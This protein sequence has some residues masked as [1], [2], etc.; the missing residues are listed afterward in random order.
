MRQHA[1]RDVAQRRV[2][3]RAF[4]H[5]AVVRFVVL[6][7]KVR[8]V[9]AQRQQKVIVRVVGR[10]KQRDGFSDNALQCR[11]QFRTDFQIRRVVGS[12]IDLVRWINCERDYQKVLACQ[13]WRIDEAFERHGSKIN[14]AC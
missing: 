3:Q 2:E 9:I 13:H 5:A 7:S 8:R 10:A 11:S 6:K 12:D 14:F 4:S 1:E